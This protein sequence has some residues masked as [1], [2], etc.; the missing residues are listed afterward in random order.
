[1][2]PATIYHR[3]LSEFAFATDATHY[4]FRLRTGKGEAQSCR[5]F[6]ADRAAMAPELDFAC[7]PMKKFREDRYFDW[8]EVRLETKLERIAYYFELSDGTET[9]CYFGDCYEMVGTPTRADFFQLPFNHRADRLSVPEWTKDAVV[10]N[11]FP[12]SFADGFRTL[13]G[14][15]DGKTGLGGTIRGI[16]ENLDYIASMGFNCIYLNPIF[17]AESYHRYDTLDTSSSEIPIAS[18]IAATL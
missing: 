15:S 14:G 11:I 4:V 7:L 12:D 13:S 9:L 2:N 6:Y 5:F 10:Y 16:A 17:A 3:P 8:Y 18:A 1:M